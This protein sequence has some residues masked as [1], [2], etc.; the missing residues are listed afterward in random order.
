MS[1]ED[2]GIIFGVG[3]AV[4]AFSFLAE[5]GRWWTGSVENAESSSRCRLVGRQHRDGI[6]TWLV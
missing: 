6:I 2:F 4:Y 5:T 1:K 3:T